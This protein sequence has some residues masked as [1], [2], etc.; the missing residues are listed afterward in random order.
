MRHALTPLL[1]V[2]L[3]AGGG[4]G[5][6]SRPG[7]CPSDPSEGAASLAILD[8]LDGSVYPPDFTPP[9]F[10]WAV[11]EADTDR[12][13]IDV[14]FADGS[15]LQRVVDAEPPAAAR[16][17]ERAL[18][19]T[20]EVYLPSN[21]ERLR[22]WTP[23]AHDWAEI[24]R[25]SRGAQ[26]TVRVTAIDVTGAATG[27]T[28]AVRITTSPDP[29]RAPIFYR[30]VPLMPSV[31]QESGVIR[32]LAD[33]AIPLIEWRLRDVSRPA[34]K[35]VLTDMPSCANCHSFS[36]DGKTLAM[37]VD[38]PTGDK[39]AYAIAPIRERMVIGREQVITWNDFDGK[40]EGHKT[41]GFL[42]RVSPDGKVVLTTL[43]EAV[44]VA[45]F[46][47]YR[48]IQVFFPTRGILVW[49]STETGEMRALPG[50]DDPAYVHTNGV[51]TPDGKS[52][53]FSRAKAS[54]PY[55]EGRPLATHPNDENEPQVRY[56][57]YRIPFDAGRGGEA[58]PIAGA[59]AN[60]MSNTFPK[61]SPDGRWIVYTKCHNGQLLRPDGRLWIVPLAGGEAREMRCNTDS[62]NSW[63]SFSPDGRW[64][65][66]TSKTNTPY[67]QMFLTHIDENGNDTPPVLIPNSTAGNRAVNL[68]EFVNIDYDGLQEIEIPAVDH[69]RHS[70]AGRELVEAGRY[71]EAIPVL[72]RA[73]EVEPEFSRAYVTLGLA[74]MELGDLVGA[75]ADFERAL[76][77]DPVSPE[78]HNDL[79]LAYLR[80][81]RVDEALPHLRRAI[82]IDFL[83]WRAEYNLALALGRKGLLPEAL[84]HF[85]RAA[86]LA[87]DEVEVATDR[88]DVLTHSGRH[89]EAVEVLERALAIH[90]E[91]LRARRML[92]RAHLAAADDAGAA[93]AFAAVVARAPTDRA[94]RLRL[95]WL[96][97]TSADDAV[98]DGARAVSLFESPY[99]APVTAADLDVYA[100]ALAE[101]GRYGDAVEAASRARALA[102]DGKGGLAPGIDLRIAA[103]EANR[104]WREPD[105][106]RARTAPR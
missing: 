101:A 84:A 63:H 61:V 85:E 24:Q 83:N 99:D 92:A 53:V 11:S 48:F 2:A 37:D 66:F 104:P 98:R 5:D 23:E 12:Y 56:D 59:S 65:V 52:I 4:C 17:D 89:A 40:P 64:M 8:P 88:G 30:D 94:A 45:N 49:Y 13:A 77:L 58:V 35:V 27:R 60:G 3:L 55:P 38:G 97:A 7:P 44:Y 6:E 72:E 43:N 47:N 103:Y 86:D 90:P 42:S 68:P 9:T 54:D 10:L 31:T 39:G 62:M 41:I 32:P 71:A 51:W 34:S 21:A 95:A 14:A 18:G 28:D 91:H 26:A 50:A 102:A 74:R 76:E 78:A 93:T 70:F 46:T 100:A 20:N 82:A 69:H 25:R 29:L 75:T 106:R 81:R 16:V 1:L 96:L 57:L 67:T 19:G 87:P 33:D 73:L 22:A 79:G 15:V 80:Q 36:Q 105:R